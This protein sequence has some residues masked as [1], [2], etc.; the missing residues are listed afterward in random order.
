[1]ARTKIKKRLTKK[2]GLGKDITSPSTCTI[3]G[4]TD[5]SVSLD[6]AD[7]SVCVFVLLDD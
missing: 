4:G 7:G 3:A 5:D 6:E 2:T 1:M